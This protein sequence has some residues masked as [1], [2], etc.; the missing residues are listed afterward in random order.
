MI[1]YVCW[2]YTQISTGFVKIGAR[3]IEDEGGSNFPFSKNSIN[4][5]DGRKTEIESSN[6]DLFDGNYEEMR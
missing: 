1:Y 4:T 2:R 3:Y 6:N 5:E